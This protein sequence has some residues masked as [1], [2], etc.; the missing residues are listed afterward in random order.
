MRSRPSEIVRIVI[1]VA[2]QVRSLRAIRLACVAGAMVSELMGP[3]PLGL[4]MVW[5]GHLQVGS[6]HHFHREGRVGR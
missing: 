4:I 2:R 6:D 5:C 1:A 3:I